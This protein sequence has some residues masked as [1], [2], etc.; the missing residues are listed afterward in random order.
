M[1]V[2]RDIQNNKLAVGDTV[3]FPKRHSSTAWLEKGE[4]TGFREWKGKI[5]AAKI[6]SDVTNGICDRMLESVVKL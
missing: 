2:I 6:R 5:V 1:K 3:V 4:I